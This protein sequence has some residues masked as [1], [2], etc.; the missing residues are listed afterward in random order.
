MSET[1]HAAGELTARQGEYGAEP[2][3]G[4]RSGTAMQ[5]RGTTKGRLCF[6]APTL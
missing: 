3:S 5:Q 2:R 4:F 1:P 6:V